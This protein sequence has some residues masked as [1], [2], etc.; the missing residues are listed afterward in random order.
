MTTVGIPRSVETRTRKITNEKAIRPASVPGAD[1][2][3]LV[4]V[5]ATMM[6]DVAAMTARSV[7]HNPDRIDVVIEANSR[8][9]KPALFMSTVWH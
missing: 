5:R 4:T 8:E 9:K 7:N 2:A 3:S 1:A 6:S